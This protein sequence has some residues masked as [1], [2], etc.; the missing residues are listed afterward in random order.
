L[1]HGRRVV[2]VQHFPEFGEQQRIVHGRA[3]AKKKPGE[4]SWGLSPSGLADE[5]RL[6]RSLGME[7]DQEAS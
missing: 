3:A 2:L 4:E 5:G 7:N 6:K 1:P